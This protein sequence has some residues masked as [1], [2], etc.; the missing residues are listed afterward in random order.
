MS[1]CIIS[2]SNPNSEDFVAEVGIPLGNILGVK[3]LVAKVNGEIIDLATPIT[4]DMILEEVS[5]A[6]VLDVTRHTSSH[7]LAQAVSRLYSDI[8]I[9]LAAG[10]PVDDGFYYD[11]DTEYKFS[12]S[13]FEK[14]EA[15]MKRIIAENI[16][17]TRFELSKEESLELLEKMKSPLKME[18]VTDKVGVGDVSSFY[19]QA[20]FTDWCKGPHVPS[21]G[22]INPDSFKIKSVAGAYWMG[23]P[24]QLQ[25]IYV[26]AFSDKEELDAHLA[27]LVEA[28]KRDHRTLGKSEEL[29]LFSFH[30]EAQG[31]P[32]WHGNGTVI[33]DNVLNFCKEMNFKRGFE[34]IR[35]ATLLNNEMWKKSG[36]WDNYKDKMYATTINEKDNEMS[37]DR[38]IDYAVKPMNCPGGTLVYKDHHYSYRDLPV[39]MAEFGFVHRHEQSGELHGLTRVRGFTQDDAH[40]YCTPSQLNDEIIS[41]IDLVH[42][43]Y[44]AFGFLDY[45]VE[46]S[47]RPNNSIGT[48]EQWEAAEAALKTALDKKDMDYTINEG[49]GAFYGPKIDYHLKDAIGRSWQCGTIQ[50]DFSMPERFGLTYIAEDGTKQTPIMIHRAIL[51]SLERFVSNLIEHYAGAM[52]TWL[53]PEQVRILPISSEK[54]GG[55]ANEVKDI[56]RSQMI[57]ATVDDKDE[58][59]QHKIRL[60]HEMKVPYMLIVGKREVDQ[61]TV[62]VRRRD[63]KTV[64]SITIEEFTELVL[65]EN[66]DRSLTYYIG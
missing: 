19:K 55:Y 20:D 39:K 56:L 13:D 47:T 51:G 65:K 36:H 2:F 26:Y 22:C 35:T 32:F 28:K 12:P 57:R 45:K 40:I 61:R 27:M 64:K 63:D 21:T 42:S 62:S 14:I 24:K 15:E 58:S 34:E 33:F 1:K 10:P 3:D 30:K 17:V 8:D 41:V 59:L 54:F 38:I 31:F 52:P 5:A 4:E 7:I 25:R 44:S 16:P 46:L 48:D 6:E 37:S 23:T 29:D 11:F 60:A 49:D 66:K 53:A 9:D 50:V 18:M 43:T